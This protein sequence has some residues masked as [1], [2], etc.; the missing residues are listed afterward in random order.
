MKLGGSVVIRNGNELDF[1]WREC[2]QSLLPVCDVVSVCDGE[3]T[4]GTQ[5]EIR[6]WMT[7]EPKL[8]LCVYPWPDPVGDADFFVKWINYAREHVK[9]DYQFQMDADEALSE[10]SYDEVL[11]LKQREGRFSVICDRLNFWR[12]S[13][14]LIPDG[15]CCGHKV[16][17]IA[18][19]N[20]W[21]AS[22]GQHPLGWEA[23]QIAIESSIKIFHY[24]FLRKREAFFKK[25]KLL[26]KMFFNNW[27][28]RLEAA[29]KHEGNWMEMPD[30]TGWERQ[31]KDYSGNHPQ[32]AREWLKERGA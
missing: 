31:L 18:P 25:E 26:Q 6:D 8:S 1:C 3:S 9:A 24:G 7:R 4:D 15:Q 13:K 23:P 21:L 17:R 12:D 22:D 14:H 29:Q 20:M 32:V 16:I 11:K 27:D 5:E 2:I 28:Q 10:E 19:Q 30:V